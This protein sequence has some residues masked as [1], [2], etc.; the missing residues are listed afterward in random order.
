MMQ[1]RPEGL[2][3]STLRKRELHESIEE[4]PL[5][6]AAGLTSEPGHVHDGDRVAC[7]DDSS[8][9]HAGAFALTAQALDRANLRP[10]LLEYPVW[11]R[12]RPQHLLRIGR[13]SRRIWRLRFP[14]K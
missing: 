10:R 2:L 7:R 5:I 4:Q 12:W 9:E 8:S 6:A 14:E 11:A 3:P 1:L 13:T